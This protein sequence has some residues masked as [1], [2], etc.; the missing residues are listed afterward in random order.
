MI[1]NNNR[2]KNAMV[3]CKGKRTIPRFEWRCCAFALTNGKKRLPIDFCC[4]FTLANGAFTLTKL[5]LLLQIMHLLLQIFE[6]K[7]QLT[8]GV[9]FSYK[10]L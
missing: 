4:A 2:R 10:N 3:N 7:I 8:Q 9:S 1:K 5:H 6:H